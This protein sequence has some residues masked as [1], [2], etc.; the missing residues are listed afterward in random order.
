MPYADMFRQRLSSDA[1]EWLRSHPSPSVVMARSFFS[2]DAFAPER[3]IL[4]LAPNSSPSQAMSDASFNIGETHLVWTVAVKS[5]LEMILTWELES[6]GL[7]KGATQLAFDPSTRRVFQGNALDRV[8]QWAVPLIPLHERYAEYLLQG[9]VDEI[10]NAAL[11]S[12]A[13]E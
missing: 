4:S 5:P 3:T 6:L 2:S 10:E 11:K 1:N 12:G 8:P 9:M 13:T 7:A